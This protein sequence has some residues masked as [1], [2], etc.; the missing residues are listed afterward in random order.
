MK[1][2]RMDKRR[3]EGAGNGNENETEE[4]DI[5]DWE[6]RNYQDTWLPSFERLKI[7]LISHYKERKF[8]S[9][10]ERSG[11]NAKSLPSMV[12]KIID[13][14]VKVM[15][16]SRVWTQAEGTRRAV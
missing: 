7:K 8:Q 12:S 9:S 2:E 14:T 10:Q 11:D 6:H 16:A 15:L 4:M 5:D 1:V 3:I 13:G